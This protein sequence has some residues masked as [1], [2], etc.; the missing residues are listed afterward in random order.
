M[1]SYPYIPDPL[2]PVTTGAD[3]SNQEGVSLIID[4]TINDVKKF[5]NIVNE[6]RRSG[7]TVLPADQP[8]TLRFGFMVYKEI[9]ELNL[10]AGY[11]YSLRLA[12]YKSAS[13][14]DQ[15]LF[16]TIRP[17]VPPPV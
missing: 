7:Y 10:E 2:D 3:F 15:E 4:K 9:K 8:Q 11:Y 6:S 12:H 13:L 5:V 1:P 17:E 14:E 16:R